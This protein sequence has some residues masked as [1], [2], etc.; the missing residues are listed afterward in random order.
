M[1]RNF[2]ALFLVALLTPALAFARSAGSPCDFVD[3]EVLNALQLGQ[4]AMKVVNLKDAGTNGARPKDVDVC[5]FS[6]PPDTHSPSFSVTTAEMP[7]G[8]Q[9]LKPSCSEK[10]VGD[11]EFT[12]CTATAKDVLVTF[13]LIGERSHG[14]PAKNAFPVQIERLIKRLAG[15]GSQ[16][17][18]SK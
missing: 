14:G 5:T 3:Q 7:S 2:L 1:I 10:S 4:H 16:S 17:F 6:P 8:V 11:M 12:M 9:P 15:P 18:P 13:V